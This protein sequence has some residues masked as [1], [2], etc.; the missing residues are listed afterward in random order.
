MMGFEISP[1]ERLQNARLQ[2]VFG[3]RR[4]GGHHLSRMGDG[5]V[6]NAHDALGRALVRAQLLWCPGGV[7]RRHQIARADDRCAGRPHHLQH[8][9]RHAIEIGNRVS[10]RIL[11]RNALA[12]HQRRHFRLQLAPSGIAPKRPGLWPLG[13]WSRLNGVG[14]TDW[15]P[16]PRY[17]REHPTRHESIKTQQPR[18]NGVGA[19]KVVQEPAVEIGIGEQL[20]QTRQHVG[21]QHGSG[22]GWKP[23]SAD[24][25]TGRE[26]QSL[27]GR[28][29]GGATRRATDSGGHHAYG[30][31][32]VRWPLHHRRATATTL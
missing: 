15:Q 27:A 3:H 1:F 32:H 14:Q 21:S 24:T 7:D 12:L 2:L 20:L 18:C 10:G 6:C 22:G 9:R 19:A 28:I 4:P 29:S 25:P 23:G 30:T 13:P 31:S 26:R 17:Q 8:A 16:F 5:V 11:H